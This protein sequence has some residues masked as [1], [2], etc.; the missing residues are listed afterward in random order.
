MVSNEAWSLVHPHF[1]GEEVSA[2]YKAVHVLGPKDGDILDPIPTKI[3][4]PHS[5]IKKSLYRFIPQYGVL[6]NRSN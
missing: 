2:V 4:H 6:L 1:H 5:F 3:P